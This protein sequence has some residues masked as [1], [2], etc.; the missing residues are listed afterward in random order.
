MK[1][2]AASGS[3]SAP[4]REIRGSVS[5]DGLTYSSPEFSGTM[6]GQAFWDNLSAYAKEKGVFVR[7]MY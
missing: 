1:Q 6:D 4:V 5:R 3:C 7:L 2:F